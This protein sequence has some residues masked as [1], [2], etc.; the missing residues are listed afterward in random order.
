MCMCTC[1]HVCVCVCAHTCVH[2]SLVAQ[3][4]KMEMFCLWLQSLFKKLFSVPNSPAYSL[5]VREDPTRRPSSAGCSQW[6]GCRRS[7]R[8]VRC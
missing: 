7:F 8:K 5:Q 6:K 3:L 2:R 1:M 4:Q